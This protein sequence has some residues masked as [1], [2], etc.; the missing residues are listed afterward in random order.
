[1]MIR[2]MSLVGKIQIS[3]NSYIFRFSTDSSFVLVISE[4]HERKKG[5]AKVSGEFWN[6]S[7]GKRNILTFFGEYYATNAVIMH[8]CIYGLRTSV[9]TSLS[10]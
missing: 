1:M 3:K 2:S 8:N 4:I 7:M 9:T 6:V 10:R 5:A